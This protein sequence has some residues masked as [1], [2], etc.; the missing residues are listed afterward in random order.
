MLEQLPLMPRKKSSSV[1]KEIRKGTRDYNALYAK[2]STDMKLMSDWSGNM[3]MGIVGKSG[4]TP[5]VV[6]NPNTGEQVEGMTELTDEEILDE[7]VEALKEQEQDFSP[8]LDP[9]KDEELKDELKSKSNSIK[10][11]AD[12]LRAA[13]EIDQMERDAYW[14]VM[15]ECADSLAMLTDQ[16]IIEQSSKGW[17]KRLWRRVKNIF[18][19]K[20]KSKF[21]LSEYKQD[22]SNRG[23]SYIPENIHS[24]PWCGPWAMDWIY[25]V[26]KGGSK[27]HHFESYASTMGPVGWISRAAGQKPMFPLEMNVSMGKATNYDIWV[28]PY[29][30][31]G[32]WHALHHIRY[33]KNPIVILTFAGRTLHWKV[34]Y[35]CYRSGSIFWR[36]YYFACQD[37][38]ALNINPKNHYH[39]SSWF[40]MFVKVYD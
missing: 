10:Q 36:N 35:G 7:V 33:K 38:G 23:Y 27:Y 2:S 6:V 8:S 40:M 34:A 28:N 24:N 1:I 15:E 20:T 14:E 3:Y 19:D 22:F 37:N 5:D 4:E 25:H 26:K 30:S 21:E 11:Q 39:R 9:I 18:N 13:L 31:T 12:S 16:E 29:Y 32:R 17:F